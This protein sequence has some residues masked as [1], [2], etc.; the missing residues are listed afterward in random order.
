MWWFIWWVSSDW[1]ILEF[2]QEQIEENCVHIFRDIETTEEFIKSKCIRCW[3]E[4][5]YNLI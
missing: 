4:R 1:Q 2:T 3:K 5:I